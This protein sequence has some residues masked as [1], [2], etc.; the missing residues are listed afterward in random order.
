[1]RVL[2][3]AFIEEGQNDVARWRGAKRRLHDAIEK[4]TVEMREQPLTVAFGCALGIAIN[5]VP[6]FGIGFIV[7]FGL[8]VL[9]RANRASAVAASTITGPLVPLMY[10][11]NLLVGGFILTPVSGHND[12]VD[13]VR[14]QYLSIMKL[15]N[16]Q[17]RIFGFVD[18]IGSTFLLG[19]AVNAVLFG[20]ATYYLVKWM[21]R[22]WST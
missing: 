10:G 14:S 21:L 16:V 6:T 19:A 13:F 15:R 5:F 12:I 2:D 3:S 20:V 11:L 4:Q 18:F 1:M 8:A 7:A 9:L 22:K 17:E